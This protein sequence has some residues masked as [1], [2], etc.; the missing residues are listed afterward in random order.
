MGDLVSCLCVSRPQRYGQL[1][2]SILDF[3][4]QTYANRELVIVVDSGT[5]YPSAVQSFVDQQMIPESGP[6]VTVLPRLAK[7]QLEGLMYAAVHASGAI[8]CLWD[9][10]NLNHPDRLKEQVEVQQRFKTAVTVLTEGLYYFP[11]DHELF[12]VNMDKPDGNAAQRTLPSS[13]MAYR[14]F[15]PVMDPST[16]A[17]PSEA[18]LN[19]TARQGRKI[20]PIPG[21]PFLHL[22]GV[23]YDNLR[24]YEYHRGVAQ[25]QSRPAAWVNEHRDVLTQA[26]DQLK[27]SNSVSVE[28]GDAGAFEYVP[29]S[30]WP[31]VLYPV[32]VDADPEVIPAP[33][34]VSPP[35]ATVPPAPTPATPATGAGGN[36]PP[37]NGK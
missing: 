3:L 8:L 36:K 34:P 15:F 25:T 13:L 9:D 30:K 24:T 16:R 18:M 37:G 28:G 5:D 12:V 20:V 27:W 32:K 19:N 21:R 4:G 26:L 17:R 31:T 11:K 22:V 35:P 23:T 10:D 29:K 7:S 14:E 1:Q 6:K 33:R 2:R